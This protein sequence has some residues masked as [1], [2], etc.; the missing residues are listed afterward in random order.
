MEPAT[1][2]YE[3]DVKHLLKQWN[4][5][6][7]KLRVHESFLNIYR[8]NY[9]ISMPMENIT[10]IVHQ[11]DVAYNIQTDTCSITIFEN[12]NELIITNYT[13]HNGQN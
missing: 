3:V 11:P 6:D 12:I 13:N 2:T 8:E 10:R 4:N 9:F 1:I 5:A 7:I